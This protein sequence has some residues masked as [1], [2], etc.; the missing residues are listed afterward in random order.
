MLAGLALP[1]H[2]ALVMTNFSAPA[3]THPDRV[4]E[5]H[6]Q[7]ALPKA[8]GTSRLDLAW[9]YAIIIGG[10]A[11]AFGLTAMGV[12]LRAG[13]ES[14]RDWVV[15]TA[16]MGAAVGGVLLAYLLVTGRSRES[17]VGI[18]LLLVALAFVFIDVLRDATGE[19]GA[20]SDTFSILGAVALGA[21]ILAVIIGFVIALASPSGTPA[22]NEEL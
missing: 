14:H 21:G 16:A 19:K 17:M 18:L 15:P 20:W 1:A 2:D 7:D 9:R 6:D 13:W 11:L 5:L 8:P 22:A 12:Q 4:H 10:V 3:P